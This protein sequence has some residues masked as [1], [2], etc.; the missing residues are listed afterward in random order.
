M[1]NASDFITEDM[2][3]K[4][5]LKK[6]TGS[7][8]EVVIPEGISIIG[9]FAF[10]FFKDLTSLIIPSTVTEIGETAFYMQRKLKK[11]TLPDS[12]EEM[13]LDSFEECT[14]LTEVYVSDTFISKMWRY[15][16]ADLKRGICCTYL[17]NKE[18]FSTDTSKKLLAFIKK[19]KKSI[20][21]RICLNDDV[22]AMR[23]FLTLEKKAVPTTIDEY[24][25]ACAE[26][27]NLSAF[28]L[29]YKAENFSGKQIAAAVQEKTDKE[30][31]IKPLSVADWRKVFKF[32]VENG[33]AIISGY[34]GESDEITIPGKIGN[35]IVIIGESAFDNNR[36]L[37]K[38]TIEAGVEEI[39]AYGFF[40][41]VNVTEVH[42]EEGLTKI[43]FAAYESC[44][45]L[46]II[47]IPSSVQEMGDHVFA[48]ARDVTIQA[49]AGSYAETYAKENNI[50]FVVE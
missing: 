36:L 21:D 42:I 19:D 41:C 25:T 18:Q 3:G 24:I 32:K 44:R 23:E 39:R 22:P 2:F 16:H 26:K 29:N 5:Y 10:T 45:D 40:A 34:K 11:L 31:G 37:K 47:T 28:L 6:Y 4:V 13:S 9:S 30:L 12:V 35:N 38:V 46:Q 43:G 17:R 50:P 1:S 48:G 20:L 8:G 27:P 33:K 15:C 7:D 14:G 49:P